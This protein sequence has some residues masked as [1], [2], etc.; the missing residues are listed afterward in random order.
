MH[1]YKE[2]AVHKIK[3]HHI[4]VLKIID[5]LLCLYEEKSGEGEEGDIHR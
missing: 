3:K 5:H 4:F 1:D 2:S